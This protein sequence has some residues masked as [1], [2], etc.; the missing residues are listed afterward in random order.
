THMNKLLPRMSAGRSGGCP[1]LAFGITPK[2]RSPSAWIP[3][4]PPVGRSR[5]AR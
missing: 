3:T 4:S 2:L 1:V 5:R